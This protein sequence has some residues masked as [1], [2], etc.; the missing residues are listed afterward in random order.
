MARP[1]DRAPVPARG[2]PGLAGGPE[3]RRPFYCGGRSGLPGH[4]EQE[5][6]KIHSDAPPALILMAVVALATAWSPV[7]PFGA[8]A[9]PGADLG[10]G[11]VRDTI[12][13]MVARTVGQG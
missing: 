9:N 3:L 11:T 13:G 5:T 2:V 7:F 8:T 12:A 10:A 6:G 1:L 4:G